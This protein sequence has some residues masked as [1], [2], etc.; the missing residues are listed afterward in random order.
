MIETVYKML[1]SMSLSDWGDIGN[2]ILG[3]SSFLTAI[4]TAIVLF[5]QHKLQIKQHLLEKD[6]LN[7]Q[8]MEHQ[9]L[10]QFKKTD[11]MLTITN[12]G[13]EL[14]APV[15]VKLHSM[16]VI[17]SEKFLDDDFQKCVC[18]CP[19]LYYDRMMSSTGQLK[20]DVAV[21]KFKSED[22]TIL[23]NKVSDLEKYLCDFRNTPDNAP[24]IN[25]YYID[26]V[27]VIQIDYVDMYQI[28]RTAYFWNSQPISKTRFDQLVELSTHVPNGLYSAKDININDIIERVYY[29]NDKLNE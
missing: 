29:T 1:C 18:C 23:I 20:G 2:I 25:V 13:S 24:M 27:D 19:V 14:S 10:F 3:I 21:A 15:N 16:I 26:I 4:A 17:N 8:Q 12:A 11:E 5:K 6:K 28:S 9:P 22:Y 7:A